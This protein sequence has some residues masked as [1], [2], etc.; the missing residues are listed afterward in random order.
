[1]YLVLKEV[2]VQVAVEPLPE[3]DLC[4]LPLDGVGELQGGAGDHLARVLRRQVDLDDLPREPSGHNVNNSITLRSA[5]QKESDG[6]LASELLDVSRVYPHT[7][8]LG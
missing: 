5:A 3:R 1:M 2:V 8:V 6:R 4:G 7:Q